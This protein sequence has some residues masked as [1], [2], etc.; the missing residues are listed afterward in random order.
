MWCSTPNSALSET[1]VFV[2]NYMSVSILNCS[3]MSSAEL[4]RESCRFGRSQSLLVH[5]HSW[6]RSFRQENSSCIPWILRSS[7]LEENLAK[8][9]HPEFVNVCFFVLICSYPRRNEVIYLICPAASHSYLWMAGNKTGS[10]NSLATC[11]FER[12]VRL[13]ISVRIE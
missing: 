1:Y 2:S 13:H 4:C 9:W 11:G 5:V 7:P 3:V 12:R 8:L 10:M 6:V